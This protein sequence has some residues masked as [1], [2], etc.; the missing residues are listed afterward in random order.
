MEKP[1]EQF[2]HSGNP[3]CKKRLNDNS[4]VQR[5]TN[6][7]QSPASKVVFVGTIVTVVAVLIIR[8]RFILKSTLNRFE[9]PTVDLVRLFLTTAAIA[10]GLAYLSSMHQNLNVI[11][12]GDVI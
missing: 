5:V 12:Y 3:Y 1:H 11:Q 10:L 6:F 7:V 2:K 4:L 9:A 8:P